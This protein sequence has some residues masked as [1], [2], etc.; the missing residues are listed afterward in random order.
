MKN[1][2]GIELSELFKRATSEVKQEL[3]NDVVN[4]LK[5]QIMAVEQLKI[6]VNHSTAEHKKLEQQLSQKEQNLARMQQGDWAAV[7]D[8]A[9]QRDEVA[10]Q[11]E[12]K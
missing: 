9:K 2:E 1:I 3:E 8:S 4:R 10:E 6:K 12:R 11:T 7:P 5:Q